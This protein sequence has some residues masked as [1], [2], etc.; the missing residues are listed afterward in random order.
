MRRTQWDAPV[1][2]TR[3]CTSVPVTRKCTSGYQKVL[4]YHYVY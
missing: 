1:R 3:K 4:V 2:F